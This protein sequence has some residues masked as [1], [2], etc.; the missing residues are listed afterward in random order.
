[1]IDKAIKNRVLEL[2]GSRRVLIAGFGREGKSSLQFLRQIVPT[3]TIVVVDKNTEAQKS[4]TDDIKFAGGE[5]Y[6]DE[7]KPGD[8]V[9]KSPGISF[10][11]FALPSEVLVS[12]QTDMFLKLFGDRT[13]GVTGT[14]GKSTTVSLTEHILKRFNKDVRLAGN[15]GIPALDIVDDISAGSLIVYELSSHQL[16]FCSA[17]PHIALLLNLYKEHLDHYRDFAAY[18]MAKW[19][20]ALHQGKEDFFLLN[21]DDELIMSDLRENIRSNGTRIPVS[22]SGQR[23]ADFAYRGGEIYFKDEPLGFDATKFKLAGIHNIFNLMMAVG[24]TSLC[25]IPPVSALEAAYDFAGLPHRLEYLGRVKGIDFINDSIATIPQAAVRALQSIDNVATIILGGYDRGI[26]YGFLTDY[27]KKYPPL[28]IMLLGEVGVRIKEMLQE[29]KYQ[30][31]ME[32][33]TCFDDAVR[34]AVEITPRGKACLL[35]PAAASYDKFK[36]FEE[37]G[38]RF[39]ELVLTL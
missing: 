38:D 18:R 22:L 13:I 7:I 27:L 1:M 19:Q 21:I 9:M 15:I 37:R 35:S 14:K 20:I 29:L 11:D 26:D 17:S 8:F 4:L 31:R 5:R 36:N 39:K 16:E 23:D 24:A 33:F 30:G 12:S 25:G 28:N 6:L 3:G 32:N 10:K 2:I 34:R